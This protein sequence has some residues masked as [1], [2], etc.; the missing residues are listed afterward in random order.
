M[1]PLM[2]KIL[3]LPFL[4]IFAAG[5]LFFHHE[6]QSLEASY[7]YLDTHNVYTDTLAPDWENWTWGGSADLG[8]GL[9]TFQSNPWGGVYL[10]KRASFNPN[11]FT[12]L[13]FRVKAPESSHFRVLVSDNNN[14]L[15][16]NKLD[17]KKYKNE[18]LSD[19]WRKYIV[20]LNE[21]NAGGILINGLAL[22]ETD[23][24]NSQLL[25]DDIKFVKL[26]T[27][28]D[29]LA[30]DN[31]I[32]FENSLTPGWQNWSWG[33]TPE[34]SDEITFYHQAWAGLYLRSTNKI[35]T[36]QF[37]NIQF[38]AKVKDQGMSYKIALYDSHNNPILGFVNLN[39]FGGEVTNDWKTF[40][41]PLS[42]LVNQGQ[43]AYGVVIHNATDKSSVFFLDSIKFTGDSIVPVAIATPISSPVP[44]VAIQTQA[45]RTG[46]G[47]TAAGNTIYKNGQ[48]ITLR[49]VNWFGAE[50]DTLS[51][52][53]LWSRNYKEMIGQIKQSGFNAVRMP[54]C[55]ATLASR[56][57]TGVEYSLNAELKGL[58]STALFDTII[59]ELNAQQIYVLLDHHRPDCQAI[60]QLWTTGNY[61]EAAWIADL[62][63]AAGRYK[64]LE[65]VMGM[66]LKNEPH[67]SATW[68][69][70]NVATDWNKAAERAGKAVLTSNP[71][72]LIY[73]QGVQDNPTCSSNIGHWMGGNMEPLDCAPIDTN[74]IPADKLVLSPHVYGPDVY[75]QGYF[76]ESNYPQ[77][78][79]AI[80]AQHFGRFIQKGYTIVPGEWGGKYGEG[81]PRDVAWQKEMVSYFK[82]NKICNSFYW[83]W[84]PNSGDTGG[85]LKDDWKSVRQDKLTL[86]S[87]YFNSCN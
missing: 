39:Q 33:G 13:E 32:I 64:S 29:V 67:G 1:L 43:E 49:G 75:P 66:D 4:A 69:T 48:K 10:H 26:G 84:N 3:L 60:S 79:P 55:P 8:S 80:W 63:N 16:E 38:M 46:G 5:L 21:L 68:G 12:H 19:G 17:L 20:D 52:H 83:S 22:Q 72:L 40:T 44:Q 73:V 76:N 41:I 18:L 62:T 56:P 30:A 37:K 15:I 2:P 54:F 42:A 51:P 57:V 34:F 9:I 50:T 71:N 86:L 11:Q 70:G 53:G 58:N 81:D 78:L 14:T 36:T 77:N 35:N 47:Y 25:F 85:I 27:Q 65:Y 87:D 31:A 28:S 45:T 7:V 6:S 23:G 59:N 24:A 61:T 74:A 82:Q